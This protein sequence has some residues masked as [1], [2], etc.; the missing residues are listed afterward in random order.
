MRKIAKKTAIVFTTLLV[1]V[2]VGLLVM[3]AYNDNLVDVA[4]ENA[5]RVAM[6]KEKEEYFQVDWDT[7]EAPPGQ[8]E[9]LKNDP[10][11]GLPVQDGF[12][13]K[14]NDDE[15]VLAF[16]SAQRW[17]PTAFRQTFKFTDDTMYFEL[18]HGQ[19]V[20][21][22][23]DSINTLSRKDF[24]VDDCVSITFNKLPDG[25]YWVVALGEFDESMYEPGVC[26]PLFPDSKEVSKNN[27]EFLLEKSGLTRL[28]EAVRGLCE[29]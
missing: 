7:L 24:K 27:L 14:I 19:V 5:D 25:G 21:N 16:G 20:D 23:Y 1:I 15:V 3:F 12:I 4:E 10:L 2:G 8:K 17:D 28:M 29:K 18:P 22:S 6:E 13:E 26:G 9:V 11:F